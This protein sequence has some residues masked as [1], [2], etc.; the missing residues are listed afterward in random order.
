[1]LNLPELP[2]KPEKPEKPDIDFDQLSDHAF[3]RIAQIVGPLVPVSRA[4]WWRYV[5]AGKAPL[6]V[7]LG[8]GVTAWRVGEL[9]AWLSREGF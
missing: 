8:A 3:V 7:K 2:E 1:M 5:R 4:T 9:R 6:P